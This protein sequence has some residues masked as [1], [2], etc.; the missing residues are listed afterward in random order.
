MSARD[1]RAVLS[2]QISD[3]EDHPVWEFTN[4]DEGDDTKV[5]PVK[6]LPVSNSDFR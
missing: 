4:N 1:S 2:L 5:R 3:L 6:R